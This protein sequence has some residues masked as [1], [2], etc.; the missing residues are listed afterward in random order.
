LNLVLLHTN[1]LHGKLTAAA[2]DRLLSL[3]PENGLYLDSGDCVKAGNL[4][5]PLRDDPAWALLRRA[6][7]DVGVLGNRE[8]Q[9]VAP[10]FK[11]KIAG[12]GHP[13]LCGNLRTKSGE[14][15]LPGTL[16][17]EAGGFRVGVVGVMVPMV[18]E[19]MATK[20]ASA[21]L[22]DP[23]IP[24]A[25]ALATELR[26]QVDCLIALTHIG[27]AEDLKLAEACPSFDLVLGGH[28]HLALSSPAR[29]GRVWVM[30]GGSHGRL[31]GRY[32]W[33]AKAGLVSAELLPLA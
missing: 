33:S 23:P 30:Q 21:Y 28:S 24:T 11:G 3:K 5:V 27:Y 7:C 14:R 26:S 29:V 20:A 4:A 13:L 32:E 18:T 8:T 15:P 16:V 31:V 2:A 19:R 1:D 12:A 10:A 6:G 25:A 17:L 9:V 22:W